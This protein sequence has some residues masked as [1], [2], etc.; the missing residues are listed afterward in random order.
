MANGHKK[1]IER[2]MLLKCFFY[3]MENY[4]TKFEETKYF[5]SIFF[6]RINKRKK[7]VNKNNIILHSYKN[8]LQHKHKGIG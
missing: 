2:G 3:R 4:S 6:E 7:Q 1:Y 8:H 5:F